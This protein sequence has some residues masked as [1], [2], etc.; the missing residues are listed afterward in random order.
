MEVLK[1]YVSPHQLGNYLLDVCVFKT[2]ELL[3]PCSGLVQIRGSA[4]LLE[5]SKTLRA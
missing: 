4:V 1:K 2:P 3:P 5:C